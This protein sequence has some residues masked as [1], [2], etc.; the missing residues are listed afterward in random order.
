MR[1]LSLAELE[2]V[3]GGNNTWP[4]HE[5]DEI[6]V[7]HPGYDH[8]WSYDTEYDGHVPGSGGG[9]N[10][11]QDYDECEDRAVDTLAADIN[12]E[13][14]QAPNKDIHEYGALIYRDENG[15]LQR[16]ALLEGNNYSLTALS[17]ALP[18]ELGFTSWEQVVGFIH[19]HPSMV[20]Q[21]DGS[22]I[23]ITPES[24]W[25]LPSSGDWAFADF[26]R[27]MNNDHNLTLYISHNGTVKEFDLYDNRDQSRDTTKGSEGH[28]NES[29]DYNP[30]AACP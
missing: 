25:D 6:V 30:G 22:Y 1:E 18:S 13:I 9:G 27:G 16:T 24:R 10:D 19:S 20:E 4:P 29:G 5:L 23:P 7:P 11:R 26:L 15:N 12:A 17:G 2:L 8:D 14:Q 21:E 3:S 28:G